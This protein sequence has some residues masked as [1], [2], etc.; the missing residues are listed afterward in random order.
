MQSG[1]FIFRE[2]E[3]AV[4]DAVSWL[5]SVDLAPETNRMNFGGQSRHGSP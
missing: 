1:G 5:Y 4:G 3:F 2:D